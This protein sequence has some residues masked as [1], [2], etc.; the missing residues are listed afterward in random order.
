MQIVNYGNIK[1]MLMFP[2]ETQCV[3]DHIK[4]LKPNGLMVEWGTGGSTCK[5]LEN[6]QHDQKLITIEHESNWYYNV[7]ASVK[8]HF[9]NLPES[10]FK[11][12]LAGLEEGFYQY[13]GVPQEENPVGL[14]KYIN[15]SEEIF[16]ADIF[17]IDGIARGACAMSVLLNRTKKDSV[18]FI[19]DY[20]PRVT[21][22][23]WVTQFCNVELIG[24]TL[25][26]LTRK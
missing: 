2:E 12:I 1:E 6:L 7:K 21:W 18:L 8:D 16:D 13:Y 24:T 4:N 5:W 9:G 15:P 10:K 17:F 20:K 23:N 26:K 22:Y 14:R 25:V 19:H 3:L 11:F